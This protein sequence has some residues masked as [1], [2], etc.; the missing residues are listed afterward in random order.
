LINQGV[1]ENDFSSR[2]TTYKQLNQMIYDNAT[3]FT[4]DRPG[5]HDFM[6]QKINGLVRNPIFPGTYF[7]TLV[8]GSAI[9]SV[10]DGMVLPGSSGTITVSLDN[11]ETEA[12]TGAEV[13]LVYDSTIGITLTGVNVTGRT[14]GFS[15]SYAL[16]SSNP[17]AVTAHVLLFTL[18]DATITPGSG[19]ILD[20]SFDVAESA[21]SGATSPL[22]F[23]NAN[24]S[25]AFGNPIRPV[26]YSDTG[27]FTVQ[28]RTGD[29]TC[30]GNVNVFDLQNQINMIL[31]IPQPDEN[32]RPLD[33]WTRA[34]LL[35]D[36][37]WNVFDLQRLINIIMGRSG[38]SPEMMKALSTGVNQLNVE[39]IQS[40]PGT[41]GSLGILLD[42][43]DPVASGELW[44]SYDSTNGLDITGVETTSRTSGFT[45]D[46]SK[47]ASDPSQVKLHVLY[48]NLSG[49]TIAAG[50]GS[51]LGLNF[52]LAAD[53]S[54]TNTVHL[55]NGLLANSMGDPLPT[56]ITQNVPLV[57]GWN[58][59]S[60]R[61]HPTSTLIA[62]VLSS[63]GSNFD[64][65]YAWDAT[66]GHAGA[67]HWM[68]YAPGIPGNTLE[69]LSENQGFWIRMTTDDILEITG[70][71]PTTTYISLSTLASGWNLVGYPTDDNLGMP[72]ALS[73]HGISDYS[74]VYGYHAEDVDNW[75]RYAPGVPGND[76]LELEHS[77]GYWIKVS[78]P[79]TWHVEY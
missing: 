52:T 57:S 35:K 38:L 74:L 50:S 5:S 4:L 72:V 46:F 12:A 68:R 25:N 20:I 21:T 19:P 58:L 42:N 16:D 6:Q 66:G 56:D 1:T 7:Y 71:P 17:A 33:W 62:D 47:D 65:V 51:I 63:L 10:S 14:A 60:F 37:V 23:S 53:A 39:T 24:L 43:E 8:E 26:N 2:D 76:L 59:V 34:D 77:W 40:P 69:T 3:F 11:Q 48:F 36:G 49:T 45:T 44:L 9:L 70:T 32:L 31:N 64:L 54:G 73:E 27:T 41:S 29:V 15:T 55:G 75:K 28:C 61:V 79:G 30:D 18:S 78:T 13:W 67:G 22:S